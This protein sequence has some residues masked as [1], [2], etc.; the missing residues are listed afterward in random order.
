MR[1]GCSLAPQR[2]RGTPAGDATLRNPAVQRLVLLRATLFRHHRAPPFVVAATALLVGLL[3]MTPWMV[4]AFYDD[5]TY[6]VLAKSLAS[7]DGYRYLNLP[8]APQATHFP[9]GYPAFLALVLRISPDFPTG[10]ALAKLANAALLPLMAVGAYWFCR[11]VVGWSPWPAAVVSVVGAT[12][13]AVLSMN[14]AL[15]SETLFLAVLFPT[16]VLSERLVRRGQR[17]WD[18]V[19]V[20]TMIGAL[21]LIRSVGLP[22]LGGVVLLLALRRR[23]Q[24]LA[25][26]LVT[27]GAV[28]APWVGWLAVHGGGLSPGLVANYGS[29][30]DWISQSAGDAT[31]RFLVRVV[32][33]NLLP[34]AMFLGDRFMPVGSALAS[35]LAFGSFV[36]AVAAS[37]VKLRRVAPV[38]LLFLAG[39]VAMILLWPFA[40]DRFYYLLEPLL[41]I[42]IGA[43]ATWSWNWWREGASLSRRAVGLAVATCTVVLLCGQVRENVESFQGR[44]W[45]RRQRLVHLAMLPVTEWVGTH[46]PP[47]AV[48]GTDVDPL[49]FLYTG[50]R[51][52]PLVNFRAEYHLRPAADNAP[53]MLRDTREILS[54][55]HPRYAVLRAAAPNIRNTLAASLSGLPVTAWIVDTLPEGGVVLGL[56]WRVSPRGTGDS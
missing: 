27:A 38:T 42:L 44:R 55:L 30:G 40:P 24:D 52:V 46:T 31:W 20:G 33:H 29:Y 3:V 9:P 22:V 17:I 16:L 54:A 23:W 39:Y 21:Q 19:L 41:A 8:G 10:I 14:A 50:R 13:P 48:V 53:A 47:N 26:V 37:V 43:A 32:R 56:R 49:V 4:G 7:G 1:I 12:S 5:G 45:E 18:A 35:K 15:M 25:L 6:L 51:A 11:R 36:V 34:H 28:V 2:N